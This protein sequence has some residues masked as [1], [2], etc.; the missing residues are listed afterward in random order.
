MDHREDKTELRINEL[1]Q[2]S[3]EKIYRRKHGETNIKKKK[4]RKEV[5]DE[6]SLKYSIRNLKGE[7]RSNAIKQILERIIVETFI[8]LMKDIKAEIQ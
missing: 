3:Q 2:V 4:Y 5:E 1:L 6:V 8:K 7:K